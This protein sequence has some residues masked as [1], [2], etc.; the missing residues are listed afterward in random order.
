VERKTVRQKR[1]EKRYN[2]QISVIYSLCQKMSMSMSKTSVPYVE[3]SNRR[4]YATENSS[5]FRCALKVVMVAE[6]FVT[7]DRS[8]R[9]LKMPISLHSHRYSYRVSLLSRIV[10]RGDR[11]VLQILHA[12]DRN[13]ELQVKC[14]VSVLCQLR[15][16]L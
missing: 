10:L 11:I 14:V 2:V 4:R 5:V 15:V 13:N 8:L 3:S 16:K 6:L 1:A 12:K 7:G 9:T